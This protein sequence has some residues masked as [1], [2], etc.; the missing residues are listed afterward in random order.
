MSVCRDSCDAWCSV[1]FKV[2]VV[3]QVCMLLML[4]LS[5]IPAL[6]RV[7]SLD[8]VDMVALSCVVRL[9]VLFM[10]FGAVRVSV[11]VCVWNPGVV[12]KSGGVLC[13]SVY[14]ILCLGDAAWEHALFSVPSWRQK[15]NGMAG[16]WTPFFNGEGDRLAAC[17]L[18]YHRRR[19]LALGLLPDV[20][21][22]SAASLAPVGFGVEG[23]VW[24]S[25][26]FPFCVGSR[27]CCVFRCCNVEI[28]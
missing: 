4:A 5:S 9:S 14:W 3:L 25:R 24:L 11:C 20:S 10:V 8:C 28:Q 2:S 7:V 23:F 22:S 17:A 1:G 15:R 26:M 16:P 13:S 27:L 21:I 6:L 12:W 18:R 19:D